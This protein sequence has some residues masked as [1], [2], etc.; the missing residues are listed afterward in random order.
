MR[1]KEIKRTY[2]KYLPY[3]YSAVEEYLEMM[4]AKGWLVQSIKGAFFKFKRI[5]AKKIKFSV[6]IL[7]K[8]SVFDVNDTDDALSYKEYCE[9]AGWNYVCQTGK[10]QVFYTEDDDKSIPIHTDEKEKVKSVFKYSLF[11]IIT[12]IMLNIMFIFNVK[13]ISTEFLLTS[14][15]MIFVAFAMGSIVVINTIEIISFFIWAIRTKRKT[16]DNGSNNHNSYKHLS[17]KSILIT[18]FLV[19]T[20]A[21]LLLLANFD[22]YWNTIYKFIFIGILAPIV[23]IGVVKKFISRKAYSKNT[24]RAIIIGSTLISIYITL[25]LVGVIAFWSVFNNG[26]TEDVINDKVSL[27]IM[28]F[29]YREDDVTEGDVYCNESLI[30][31]K[32]SYYYFA[33]NNSFSYTVL[34]SR[35]PLAIKLHEKRLISTLNRYGEGLKIK[36]TNLPSDI[37][38]YSSPNRDVYI[39]VSK[40]KVINTYQNLT[41]I[42]EE[43]FLNKVYETL[44][45]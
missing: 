28:D 24:N 43:E 20:I 2:L 23:I 1:D 27:S 29:G 12:F 3:E 25:M 15:L 7:N 32:V 30:A 18:V 16:K 45:D 26:T 4:A 8:I 34:N 31:K 5:E 22:T 6:D 10:I 35:F 14:N 40:D 42:S 21:L 11:N 36:D 17:V 38:V 33:E 13:M 19:L 37:K 41:G 44:L 9:A 39:V